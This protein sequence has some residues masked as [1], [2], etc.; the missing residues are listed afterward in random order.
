MVRSY[1][2]SIYLFTFIIKCPWQNKRSVNTFYHTLSLSN[3]C[4]SS[5]TSSIS[6]AYIDMRLS[7]VSHSHS[8]WQLFSHISVLQRCAAVVLVYVFFSLLEVLLQDLSHFWYF[9]LTF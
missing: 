9:Y 8:P 6:I 7:N 3:F 2:L 5:S 1:L 4:G